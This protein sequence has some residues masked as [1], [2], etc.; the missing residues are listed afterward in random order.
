MELGCCQMGNGKAWAEWTQMFLASE[1]GIREG[2]CDEEEE[3]DE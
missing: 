3:E 2:L 1:C